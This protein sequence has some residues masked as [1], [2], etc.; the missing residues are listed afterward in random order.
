MAQISD[1]PPA[2]VAAALKQTGLHAT[3]P[4]PSP[5]LKLHRRGRCIGD[6]RA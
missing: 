1:K 4:D 6:G 2:I 3:D 5:G